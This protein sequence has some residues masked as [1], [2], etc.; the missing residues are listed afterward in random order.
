MRLKSQKGVWQTLLDFCDYRFVPCL[1]PGIDPC[2]PCAPGMCRDPTPALQNRTEQNRT[3][4]VT[5]QLTELFT[6]HP[7]NV[8]LLPV[9]LCAQQAVTSP[10]QP[11]HQFWKIP[12]GFF[13]DLL[14]GSVAAQLLPHIP[15]LETLA[16]SGL[17]VLVFQLPS[18]NS[19]FLV[20]A[21]ARDFRHKGFA[22]SHAADYKTN[23]F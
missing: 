17:T 13:L 5:Q 6:A 20:S 19:D 23:R 4:P 7:V 16:K 12:Q 3:F 1:H 2:Q 18:G 10:S 21:G 8:G 15:L 14:K 9:H 22:A 11:L